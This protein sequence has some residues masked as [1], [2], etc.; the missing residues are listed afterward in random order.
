MTNANRCNVAP[1]VPYVAKL[2]GVERDH[3]W[4][5][6]Q[7][8]ENGKIFLFR[9]LIRMFAEVSDDDALH[10]IGCERF[11]VDD[12]GRGDGLFD[13]G[14]FQEFEISC[15]Q[16]LSQDRFSWELLGHEAPD[17]VPVSADQVGL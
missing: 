3:V 10:H 12:R 8:I 9:D 2:L 7:L 15:P 1:K 6:V 14:S 5:P 4:L 11:S 16:S 13:S 17:V